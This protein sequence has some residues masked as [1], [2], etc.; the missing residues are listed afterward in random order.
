[1]R[2]FSLLVKPASADCNLDC[3]YCFYT[4][5]SALY[6]ETLRHRMSDEVLEQMMRNFF[7]APQ[8]EFAFGWQGGEP[9]LMGQA[10][11][12]RAVELQRRYA[13]PGS[14]VTNGLQTNGTLIDDAFAAWLAENRFLVGIS[15]DGPADVHDR[16]RRTSAGGGSHAHVMRGLEALERHGVEYNVLALVTQ[17]N[18]REPEALYEYLKGLGISHHQY[19]PCV[20]TDE[21]GALT[22]YSVPGEEW[23]AFLCGLFDAWAPADAAEVSIRFFDSVLTKILNGHAT[24]CYMG[25]DCRH[26][27]VVEHSGDIYPCDFY[28]EPERKLGNVAHDHFVELWRSAAY[29]DF[30]REKRRWGETC[31]GCPYLEYC[32]GDC[33]KMRLESGGGCGSDNP[34]A[35]GHHGAGGAAGDAAAVGAGIATP[36]VL[37]EGWKQFYAHALPRLEELA[38]EFRAGRLRRK[39]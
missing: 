29:R 31:A 4:A 28:V 24:V 15:I 5:K 27:F 36:S 38:I 9:T 39:E 12:E 16:Y 26:Y 11:F 20:E 32:A 23:G 17:A 3:E 30:G 21:A 19:I 35:G 14:T 22:D 37:C 34:A 8:R 18:V 33:P 13:P 7:A 6:P 25:K 10:F 2:P 1:M